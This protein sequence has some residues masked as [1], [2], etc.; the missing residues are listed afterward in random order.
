MNTH[1]RALG[2]G[3]A[4]TLDRLD[5]EGSLREGLNVTGTPGGLV[6]VR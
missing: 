6:R 4:K 3:P 2:H 5:P 1:P